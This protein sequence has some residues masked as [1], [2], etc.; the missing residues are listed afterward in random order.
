M[1]ISEH[2]SVLAMFSDLIRKE[3]TDLG[4]EKVFFALRFLPSSVQ[5]QYV[6]SLSTPY[7]V[8]MKKLHF[9]KC[10]LNV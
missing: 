3:H 6:I 2:N 9:S 4:S 1:M 8:L 10:N 5:L 7:P